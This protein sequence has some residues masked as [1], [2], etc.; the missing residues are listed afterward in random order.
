MKMGAMA[1]VEA[2]EKQITTLSL[3]EAQALHGNDDAVFVDIRDV[4][5]LYREGTIPGSVH[6]PRGMLEFWVDP[7]SPYH[8]EVFAQD[9]TYVLYCAGALRSAL[10]TLALQQMGMNKVCQI[11]GGFAAWKGAELPIDPVS[12]TAQS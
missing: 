10:A 7:A 6:A 8:R 12:P 5:E 1:L 11:A 4:R 3:E 9:K 2:A